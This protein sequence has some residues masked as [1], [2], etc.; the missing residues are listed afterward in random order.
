MQEMKTI[1]RLG[2]RPAGKP[3]VGSFYGIF[4][5]VCALF[6]IVLGHRS[7]LVALT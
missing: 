3:K 6:G 4:R 1:A 7:L 5:K 2:M